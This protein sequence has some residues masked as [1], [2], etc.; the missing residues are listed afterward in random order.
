MDGCVCGENCLQW[1]E[2]DNAINYHV[3]EITTHPD[4]LQSIYKYL[5]ARF[6]KLYETL[7]LNFRWDHYADTELCRFYPN[8]VGEDFSGLKTL[9]FKDKFLADFCLQHGYLPFGA[10]P[11]MNYDRFCFD[12]NRPLQN[13]YPIVC[14][15]H[16]D[17]LS[18]HKIGKPIKISSSFEKF[19]EETINAR[20]PIPMIYYYEKWDTVSD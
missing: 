5:P 16:E 11:D 10:G 3:E 15:D 2:N 7:I 13:D 17:V 12:L 18:Y 6:P 4:Q 19:V 1:D 8:P 14:V 20:R 9:M